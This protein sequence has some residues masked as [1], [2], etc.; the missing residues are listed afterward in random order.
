MVGRYAGDWEAIRLDHPVDPMVDCVFKA[1]LGDPAN[2]DLLEDFLNALLRPASPIVEVEILNPYN[3]KEME[4]DKL[5]VVDVKARDAGGR[6]FQVE[7]QL[8]LDP[9]LRHRMVYTWSDVY[10]GQLSAGQGYQQLAPVI[11]IW[12]LKH[13]L[14]RD[15]A[16][17]HHCFVLSDPQD[18]CR[19]S[20]HLTIH[21]WELSRWRGQAGEE[22][23]ER[24]LHFLKEGHRWTELPAVLN[25]PT[26]RKAMATLQRF[27]DKGQDYWRY[28]ARQNY[29]REQESDQFRMRQAEEGRPAAEERSCADR[30]QA[31]P[32]HFDMLWVCTHLPCS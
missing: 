20:D 27:S 30:T 26:M 11:S 28:Q 21:V 25:T 4:A 2:V 7:V 12:L 5:T 17:A 29:L 3:D 16:L 14:L 31:R 13:V 8:G 1:L 9:E 19:L 15:S 22:Q 18:G 23:A 24:W 6:T 32:L 10:Q